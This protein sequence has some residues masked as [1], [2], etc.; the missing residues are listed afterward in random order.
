MRNLGD[1]I[2]RKIRNTGIGGF[3]VP[4]ATVVRKSHHTLLHLGW[5]DL[6]RRWGW[7]ALTGVRL[8]APQKGY[9]LWD[10]LCSQLTLSCHT[11]LQEPHFPAATA[12][13]TQL[14]QD[15]PH[16][17]QCSLW[18]GSTVCRR[19]WTTLPKA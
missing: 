6:P 15:R 11:H 17:A 13:L 14:P 4:F 3:V 10:E 7:S 8:A 5:W 16:P 1:K 12:A 18:S 9:N 2:S 19:S